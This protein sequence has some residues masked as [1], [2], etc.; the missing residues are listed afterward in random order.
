MSELKDALAVLELPPK[1][2]RSEVQKA[3]RELLKVWHPDRF[4]GDPEFQAEAEEKTKRITLAATL[5]CSLHWQE[6]GAQRS[7]MPPG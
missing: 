1:T 6:I 3:Y 5:F 4:T 2:T 7:E